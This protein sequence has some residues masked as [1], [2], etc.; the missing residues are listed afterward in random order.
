MKIFAGLHSLCQQTNWGDWICRNMKIEKRNVDITKNLSQTYYL[1]LT[2]VY[3]SK[4]YLYALKLLNIHYIVYDKNN[5]F[6]YV[7]NILLIYL[8]FKP[9]FILSKLRMVSVPSILRYV[10]QHFRFPWNWYHENFCE[11]DFHF[12]RDDNFNSQ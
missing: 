2:L 4:N 9:L 10:D 12:R 3:Y 1:Y 11:I 7:K 8:K 5:I 6:F